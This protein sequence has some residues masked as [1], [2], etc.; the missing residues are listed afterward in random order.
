VRIGKGKAR[1]RHKGT[2]TLKVKLSRKGARMRKLS[3]RRLR[4]LH[5]VLKIATRDSAGNRSTKTLRLKLTR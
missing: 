3:K 4:K 5:P 2:I 1:A